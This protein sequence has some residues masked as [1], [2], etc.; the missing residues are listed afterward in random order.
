MAE[1]VG[2][3]YQVKW[4][5]E[6][7]RLMQ[8]TI[9]YVE[10]VVEGLQYELRVRDLRIGE[11]EQENRR[12]RKR[13]EEQA[14]PP[15]APSGPPPPFVKPGP[16]P[17]RRKKPG[18]KEGH[19]AALRPPPGHVD[20]VVDVPL[21]RRRRTGERLC[22]HCRTPLEAGTI[23]KHRRLV[24]DLVPA[25]VE[26]V[27]YRTASG[28]CR[29]CRRRVE[30]RHPEQ[31]PPADLPHAQLGVNA[32]A[33]AAALRVEDRLPMRGVCAVLARSGLRLC[34]GAVA[35]QVQRLARWLGGEYGGIRSR[36]RRS[37]SANVDE[38]GW[39]T[40]GRNTWLW[41]AC[42]AGH[43]LYHVDRSRAGRVARRML[44]ES[45]GGTVGCDF[46]GGYD[47]AGFGRKQRCLAHLLRELRETARDCPGF[48]AGAFHP[49]CRRLLKDMLALKR[50]WHGLGDA[51]YT[52]RACRIGDRLDALARAHAADAEPHARRLAAR[53]TRHRRELTPF[54][55]DEH[56]GGTN[57]AAERA[58]RPAVVMRKITGGSR[59]EAGAQAWAVLAS[60]L[61]TAK[62][63]GRDPVRTLKQLMM[64]HWAGTEPGLLAAD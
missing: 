27:C 42:A 39:R 40:C 46:Y 24:E 21:R 31:P 11:L 45:F 37:P 16:P 55:W 5:E 19:E 7:V 32:L 41:A 3:D 61:R 54:L 26:V 62:Q 10:S 25:R 50:R 4:L 23:K 64:R 47:A 60:V 12:L 48:A 9:D 33:E 56:L 49:R 51:T 59:S 52:R 13:L 18:R 17:G 15:P 38:T 22:P 58:L 6:K 36:L 1:P 2:S 8:G 43:T 53:L 20:R 14:P 34:A 28:H 35:R 30:S 57:N 29:H 44:G 63:Q